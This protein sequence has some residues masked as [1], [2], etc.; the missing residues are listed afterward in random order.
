MF[1]KVVFIGLVWPEPETTAAG[2]RIL[3]LIR[4]FSVRSGEVHF[5]S[6]ALPGDYSYPLEELGVQTHSIALNDSSFDRWIAAIDPEILV[7]DRFVTEEQFS[8]RVRE[9]C[10]N[11]LRI[12]DTEDLHSLRE[13]RR[14]TLLDKGP[15]DD[16]APYDDITLR[17]LASIYRSDLSLIISEVE[18]ELLTGKFKVPAHL[19]HYLPFLIS[20][21][22]LLEYHSLP[23]FSERVDFMTIGNW[24]HGPNKDSVRHLKKEIWPLIRKRLPKARIHIYGAYGPGEK[25]DLH[26]PKTGFLIEGWKESK[27]KAFTS[28][29]VCLAP[30][31]YG[32]GLKGKLFDALKFG[33]PSVT[34]SV[35]AEGISDKISWNGF[36]CDHPEKFAESAVDLY[37]EENVWIQA[38]SRGDD[39]L[40][41]RFS[42]E[43]F[44]PELIKRIQLMRKDLKSHRRTNI[45]GALLWHHSAQSTKYLS[46]W[47]EAKN[48]NGQ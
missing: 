30:L 39:I 14:L 20:R 1:S 31:R 25:S 32:A 15:H 29:R 37:S 18:M 38:Q 5:A 44:L 47:I 9:T 12:L 26:D 10:P 34:T 33:T 43:V 3:Q 7:F 16:S 42:E 46:K 27:K 45:T 22:R 23:P 4:F 35:G 19:L 2:S 6:T 48:K 13:S 8:W 36:V 21:E 11:A 24:K 28:H 41:T 40:R 17:E